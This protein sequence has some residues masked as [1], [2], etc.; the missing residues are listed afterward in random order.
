MKQLLSNLLLFIISC[1]QKEALVEL[2][3]GGSEAKNFLLV[4]KKK[5]TW[6]KIIKC[7][8]I[9]KLSD[10]DI[11]NSK[12]CFEV[13]RKFNFL[14]GAGFSLRETKVVLFVTTQN[15]PKKSGHLAYCKIHCLRYEISNLW[16]KILLLSKFS[17]KFDIFQNIIIFI[18]NNWLS[19]NEFILCY[20]LM[21]L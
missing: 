15:P 10:F 1:G 8:K 14:W 11:N 19:F 20:S 6:Y 7:V 18:I 21:T 5:C 12:F 13:G 2:L 16:L 9:G 17:S 3:E 4:T